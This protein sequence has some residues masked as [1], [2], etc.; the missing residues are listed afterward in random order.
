MPSANP[1]RWLYWLPTAGT[2][3]I[4][5]IR[6]RWQT[7]FAPQPA[8][9]I[10][11]N[12]ATPDACAALTCMHNAVAELI[13]HP[14]DGSA[15]EVLLAGIERV[16]GAQASAVFVEDNVTNTWR[17]LACTSTAERTRFTSLLTKQRIGPDEQLP[18]RIAHPAHERAEIAV[19]P[20]RD[21]SRTHHGVLL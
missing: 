8:Q 5:R 3:L 6:Q 12:A 14:D 17:A 21:R 16:S 1:T 11:D 9:T 7:L 20:V 13:D 10:P 2:P 15:F 19:L 4:P 18:R